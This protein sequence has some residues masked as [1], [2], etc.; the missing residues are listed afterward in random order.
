MKLYLH[1]GTMKTGSTTLQ[2]TLLE[3]VHPL[4]RQGVALPALFGERVTP[5][6]FCHAVG[7]SRVVAHHRRIGAHIPED[8]VIPSLEE[9]KD[10]LLR[11]FGK[12]GKTCVSCRGKVFPCSFR[13][14]KTCGVWLIC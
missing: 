8:V 4:A 6:L 3:N 10:H 13:R 5:R 7:N 12:S 14:L 2:R 11:E 1:I 9:A